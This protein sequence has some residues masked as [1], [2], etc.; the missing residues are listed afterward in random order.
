MAKP[1]HRWPPPLQSPNGPLRQAIYQR[2]GGHCRLRLPGCTQTPTDLD[3]IISPEQGG[4][5]F[6][7][8]NLRAA[9]SHCNS[10]RSNPD[11]RHNQTTT[12]TTPTRHWTVAL[13]LTAD[14]LLRLIN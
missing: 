7:P 12:P 5:W 6:D 3:H 8:N 10:A 13:V 14:I 2:D 9:C 4:E 11:S 1:W